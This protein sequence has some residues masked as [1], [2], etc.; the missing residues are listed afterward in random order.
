MLCFCLISMELVLFH[1]YLWLVNLRACVCFK[2]ILF[3]SVLLNEAT[4]SQLQWICVD[5]KLSHQ[6]LF[7]QNLEEQGCLFS[8]Q[9]GLIAKCSLDLNSKKLKL[10]ADIRTQIQNVLLENNFMVFFG[11]QSALQV[12]T[13]FLIF[14]FFLLL[15]DRNNVVLTS[16]FSNNKPGLSTWFFADMMSRASHCW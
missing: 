7:K 12:F 16:G 4:V 11:L 3:T 6:I 5:L 13:I 14:F 10:L 2:N 15:D 9:R 1:H 8:S